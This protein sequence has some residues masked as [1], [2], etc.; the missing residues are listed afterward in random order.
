M[1]LRRVVPPLAAGLATAAILVATLPPDLRYGNGAR[2]PPIEPFPLSDL[3][4]NL[5]LF[6]PLGACLAWS[7]VSARRALVLAAALSAGIELAQGALIPGR[8]ASAT[9]WLANVA[10]TGIALALFRLAPAWLYP[11]PARSRRL[12]LAAGAAATAVL[13]ATGFLAEPAP[14]HALYFGLHA[15]SLAHLAPYGGSVIDAAIGDTEIPVGRLSA[16]DR[17]RTQLEG[18]YALRVNARAAAQPAHLAAWLMIADF[19][20]NEILLLGPDRDDLVYRYRNLGGALGL[21]AASVRLPHALRGIGPGD[22]VALR[23]ERSAGDLCVA[24]DGA[25][26][27]GRGLTVGDGWR[28]LAPDYRVLAPWQPALAAAWIAA[29]FVP[30]GY[31]GRPSARNAVAWAAAAGA[32]VLVPAI[33]PLRPTPVS[34]L[35]G[36]GLGAA[37]GM[38]ARRHLA[39]RPGHP[40]RGD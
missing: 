12:G 39:A 29:W 4:R 17:I 34:Q 8:N 1:E 31:W 16:S 37:F 27:C 36:A 21:E 14:T 19:D 9:D 38:A 7:R 2:I 11:P 26:H 5:V 35:V 15:P 20:Q 10:G 24:V 32:L 25:A 22:E 33:A 23:V 13:L 30:L 28:F 40:V 6:A 3:L 18:D